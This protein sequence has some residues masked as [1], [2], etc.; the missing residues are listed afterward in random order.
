MKEQLLISA[1]IIGSGGGGGAGASCSSN[2]VGSLGRTGGVGISAS[3]SPSMHGG[4]GGGGIIT[5]TSKQPGTSSISGPNI[6]VSST[7]GGSII[8]CA[9]GA[10]GVPNVMQFDTENSASSNSGGVSGK[11]VPRPPKRHTPTVKFSPDT[12]ANNSSS[13]G[14]GS[15]ELEMQSTGNSATIPSSATTFSGV[16]D[17]GGNVT[18]SS[19]VTGSPSSTNI[20]QTAN[21][22]VTTINQPSAPGGQTLKSSLKKN[23]SYSNPSSGMSEELKV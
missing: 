6:S 17:G 5:T 15:P 4:G 22:N 19:V 8:A 11:N 2:I 10:A 16:V 23:S 18:L 13:G 14:N 7:G 9:T 12:F 1:G 3:A 20:P 21:T